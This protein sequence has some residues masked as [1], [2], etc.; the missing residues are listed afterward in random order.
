MQKEKLD[1]EL[2]EIQNRDRSER[3][4]I[5]SDRERMTLGAGEEGR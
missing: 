1:L 2:Y 3:R 4:R 5:E